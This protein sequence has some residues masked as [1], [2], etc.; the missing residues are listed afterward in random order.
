MSSGKGSASRVNKV[1][2]RPANQASSSSKSSSKSRKE[3]RCSFNRCSLCLAHVDTSSQRDWMMVIQCLMTVAPSGWALA[4]IFCAS[5]IVLSFSRSFSAISRINLSCSVNW[6][7]VSCSSSGNGPAN[8]SFISASDSHSRSICTDLCNCSASFSASSNRTDFFLL[9]EDTLSHKPFSSDSWLRIVAAS[10]GVAFASS[11]W[12]VC[13]T[14]S[15][16]AARFA[17]SSSNVLCCST[18][19]ITV[20]RSPWTG[21]S[22]DK[23]FST[24]RSH[25]SNAWTASLNWPEYSKA[26]SSF[27]CLSTD[28]AHTAF[29]LF[30][31]SVIICLRA[32]SSDLGA[33][34]FSVFPARI[35]AS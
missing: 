19:A 30:L 32:G 25:S 16:W 14:D 15:I 35:V 21:P 12:P 20:S 26:S 28:F 31:S 7:R 4:S 10:V 27:L 29:H 22:S 23:T 1:L 33:R 8:L 17:R 9:R 6:L 3:R 34:S 5:A 13:L 18:S 2:S 24:F 11:S